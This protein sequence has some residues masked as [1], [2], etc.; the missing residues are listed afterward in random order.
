MNND[1]GDFL[2]GRQVEIINSQLH[3]SLDWGVSLH[4]FAQ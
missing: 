3:E 4:P 1:G 2:S